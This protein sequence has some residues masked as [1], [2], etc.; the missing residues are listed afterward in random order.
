MA[1]STLWRTSR[2]LPKGFSYFDAQFCDDC[3]LVLDKARRQTICLEAVTGAVRW[4]KSPRTRANTISGATE[5]VL[6]MSEYRGND[7][8]WGAD[9]GIY[10]YDLQS[11][12]FLG[13]SQGKG[14]WGRIV[15][16][17][18]NVPDFTNEL[19]PTAVAVCDG[20]I[21]T[22]AG[23][24]LDA[25]SGE[26]VGEATAEELV[27]LRDRATRREV[28]LT[29]SEKEVALE[30]GAS[31]K[32]GTP[33]DPD[34]NKH[35]YEH[36]PL[37]FF[38]RDA[39][40]QIEWTFDSLALGWDTPKMENTRIVPVFDGDFIVMLVRQGDTFNTKNPFEPLPVACC[41]TRLDLKTGAVEPLQSLAS[42]PLQGA[43]LHGARDGT[44]LV[45]WEDADAKSWELRL[46]RW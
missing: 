43:Q 23:R 29:V 11:G 16:W 33:D 27:A 2:P 4:E 18:D 10:R 39:Q 5:N 46:L 12:D 15:S 3:V 36:R 28:E 45:S 24:V 19:R 30:N 9:F 31:L 32:A 17:L 38:R 13:A 6:V 44:L 35:H 40:G 20:K 14:T 25:R 26:R 34:D 41:L 21:Y 37:Q 7:G 8:P 42:G 22:D 1:F